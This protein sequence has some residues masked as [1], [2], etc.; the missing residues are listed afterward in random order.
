MASVLLTPWWKTTNDHRE[1]P[2][3]P[4]LI[5]RTHPSRSLLLGTAVLLCMAAPAQ[6]VSTLFLD[7][8]MGFSAA[9]DQI[10]VDGVLT[11]ATGLA[12]TPVV[13]GSQFHLA[14]VFDNTTTQGGITTAIFATAPGV[15]DVVVTGG[16]D[17]L[18]LAGELQSL[19]AVGVNGRDSATLTGQLTPT[20]GSL[21]AMFTNPAGLLELHLDLS[22]PF[23]PGIF[24]GDFIGHVNGRLEA[25]AGPA[26]PVAPS[27]PEP[28]TWALMTLGL[29]GL[30]VLHLRRGTAP[31]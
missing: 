18:L 15:P 31:R 24:Q 10:Q 7:G 30:S 25:I 19:S 3:R 2:M 6:A 1:T 20:A 23:R 16:D 8:V 4:T 28:A 13:A 27:I 22:T 14:V 29:L 11:A 26:P 5:T 21:M 17:T 12:P 9:T